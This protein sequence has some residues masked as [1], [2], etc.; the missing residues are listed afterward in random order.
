EIADEPVRIR[1]VADPVELEVRVAQTRF[2]GRLRGLRALREFDAVGRGLHAVVADL[3]R[4]AD[5]VEEIRREG[6]LAA[7]ELHR[8]LAARLDGDR[9]VENLLDVVPGQLMYESHLVCIP[10]TWMAPHVAA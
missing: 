2:S 4:V 9:V 1:R 3:A 6:R 10:E 7:R 5:S 8:H